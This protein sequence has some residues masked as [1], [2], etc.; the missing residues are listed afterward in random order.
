[1]T[2]HRCGSIM[3]TQTDWNGEDG[4]KWTYQHC[5]LCGNMQDSTVLRNRHMGQ[6]TRRQQANTHQ[7]P[8][9]VTVRGALPAQ[10]PALEE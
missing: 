7:Y 2:C 1:M 10:V 8:Q 9:A 5:L 3:F 4:G 6:T